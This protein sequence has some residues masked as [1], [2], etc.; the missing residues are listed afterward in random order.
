W[1]F[2]TWLLPKVSSHSM[3]FLSDGLLITVTKSG[4][5]AASEDQPLPRRLSCPTSQ[6]L[7]YPLKHWRDVSEPAPG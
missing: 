1:L 7:T 6:P 4:N 3:L 2:S 5:G